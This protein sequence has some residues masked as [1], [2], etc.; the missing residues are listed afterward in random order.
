MKRILSIILAGLTLFLMGSCSKE[1]GPVYDPADNVAPVMEGITVLTESTVLSNDIADAD[2]ATFTFTP[3]SF[4]V[5]VSIKY[6]IYM[7]VQGADFAEKE[8]LLTTTAVPDENGKITAIVKVADINGFALSLGAAA[9]TEAAFEFKLTATL[10]G[11]DSSTDIVQEAAEVKTLALTPYDPPKPVAG[12]NDWSV[13]GVNNNWD[14]DIV[15]TEFYTGSGVWISEPIN[16]KEGSQFKFRQGA[17]WD[18]NYGSAAADDGADVLAEDVAYTQLTAGGKN[19]GVTADQLGRADL[20]LVLDVNEDRLAAYAMGWG[21]VGAFN[22]WGNADGDGV[23]KPDYP[24]VK[25]ESGVLVAFN[26]PLQT[27]GTKFRYLAS[28]DNKEYG[29]A[30]GVQYED[31][32][33]LQLKEKGGNADVPQAG[34]YNIELNLAAETVTF[35]YV[36]EIP[37][38]EEE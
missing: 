33:A 15:M 13:I 25:N 3:A 14:N 4:G 30:D 10:V 2:F 12:E 29:L 9:G 31:G 19:F 18:V 8:I 37:V 28:W 21:I 5:K 22:N 7:G 6:T 16:F 17:K 24:L 32:V 20:R 11:D 35:T 27:G 1:I 38:E 26:V 34:L 36:G 23:I